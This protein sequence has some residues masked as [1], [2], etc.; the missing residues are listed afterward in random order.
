MSTLSL[1]QGL[2]IALAIAALTTAQTASATYIFDLSTLVNGSAPDVDDS[3]SPYLTAS[4]TAL[5]PGE[6][7]LTLDASNLAADE[8]IS[9]W[10]FN[11]DPTVTPFTVTF[12]TLNSTLP[13]SVLLP[14]AYTS[15]GLSGG[16][17]VKGGCLHP[18]RLQHKRERR[19][20]LR[21]QHR[22]A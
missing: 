14:T 22:R 10:L 15:N 16:S 20:L 8:F 11:I 17:N 7:Q 1:K 12:D 5:A 9:S 18:V 13:S 4:V 6:M 3:S 21:G 19:P 2:W